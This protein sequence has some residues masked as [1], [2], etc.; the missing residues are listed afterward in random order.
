MTCEMGHQRSFISHELLKSDLLAVSDL[1]KGCY[2]MDLSLMPRAGLRGPDAAVY[3][4]AQSIPVAAKP[5]S[6]MISKGDELVLRLGQNSFW[7]LASLRGK[8][9]S[10]DVLQG[11]DFSEQACYP[12]HCQ[13]SHAWFAISA[14]QKSQ[15]MAKICGLD[16]RDS[17]FPLNA[18][19]QTRAAG[20]NVIIV[21]HHADGKPLFSLFCDGTYAEYLWR[22]I[23][24][25]M[26]E[27]DGKTLSM[28]E[29]I[30][31]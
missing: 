6:A 17:A 4:Q 9:D 30:A 12:I 31:A 8:N 24:D 13:H 5:N 28:A 15:I 18:I 25:A 27:F 29:F 10:I 26:A 19:A 22:V 11:A 16:L 23:S 21:H 14:E 1:S 3:C 2:L 20:I 7:I